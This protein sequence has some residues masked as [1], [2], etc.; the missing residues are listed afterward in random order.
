MQAHTKIQIIDDN[1]SET[2][3]Y[4]M[5]VKLESRT[6]NRQLLLPLEFILLAC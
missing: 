1:S 2:N 4:N 5:N 3:T 6:V